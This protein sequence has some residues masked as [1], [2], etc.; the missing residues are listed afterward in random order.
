MQ[1][2]YKSLRDSSKFKI[3]SSLIQQKPVWYIAIWDVLFIFAG[4]PGGSAGK[5]L[6]AN[7]GDVGLIPGLGRWPGE[8]NGNL[9]QYS[10]WEIPWTE[11]PGG[12]QES[13]IT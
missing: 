8:G 13:E 10:S 9:L 5:N 6:C 3:W 4:F 11:E 12:L 1:V 2:P 7:A